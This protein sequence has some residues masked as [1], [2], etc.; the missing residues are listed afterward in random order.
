MALQLNMIHTKQKEHLLRVMTLL[1]TRH[2]NLLTTNN[3]SWEQHS[4][5]YCKILPLQA[6]S[7]IALRKSLYD[8]MC[9]DDPVFSAYNSRGVI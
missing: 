3:T 4:V 7:I 9:K 2:E 5:L 8:V 1:I 6:A